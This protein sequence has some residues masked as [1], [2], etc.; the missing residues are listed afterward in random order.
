MRSFQFTF[1]SRL[2]LTGTVLTGICI[3]FLSASQ[4]YSNRVAI[5]DPTPVVTTQPNPTKAHI[6][7]AILL[8]TS[9]S[10]DG[11][12]NQTREQLWQMVDE[13]SKAKH[14][15]LPPELQVAVFEYGNDGLSAS[16]GHV[17][18]VVGLTSEL[19]RVSEALFSL[20]TNGGQ[21]Y[22]G[23]AIDAAV[24]QLDWSGNADDLRLIFIAGNEPFTQGPINYV[25]AINLA[26]QHD[27]TVSTIFAGDHQE[28]LTTGWQQGAMLAGGNFMSINHNQQIAHIDAPQDAKI[29]EL[30]AKLNQTYIPYGSQGQAAQARQR[31][32]DDLSAS[33]SEA[34]L[35]KRAK[36][37]ATSVYKNSQWDL[38]DA[39]A[40]GAV[41]LDS[42]PNEQLPEPMQ[43]MTVE[44]QT[45]YIAEKKAERD[46]LQRQIL[47]LSDEREAFVA[48]EQEKQAVPAA[49]TF[50]DAIKEA[51]SQQAEKKN[52]EFEK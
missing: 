34:Y 52:Y 8:D 14:N 20:T 25:E 51:I 4:A 17:R 38:V 42:I 47:E 33:V 29:A 23:Y 2:F 30:N 22:C 32:Q 44:E 5:N 3:A 50:N 45:H 41:E 43:A 48:K 36:A 21:E 39:T 6:Q 40:D 19:D 49:P 12:I 27:I 28:G 10:M 35:A 46:S 24:H 31:S 26:K 7:L 13:L 16:V 37:K 11:L 9:N 1:L 18:K 15:G